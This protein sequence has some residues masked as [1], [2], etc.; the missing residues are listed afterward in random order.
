MAEDMWESDAVP[1]IVQGKQL[2]NSTSLLGLLLRL[3]KNVPIQFNSIQ[4]NSAQIGDSYVNG[5]RFR[6]EFS[7][8]RELRP[9][10][11]IFGVHTHTY[12]SSSMFGRLGPSVRRGC[13]NNSSKG[14]P[15]FPSPRK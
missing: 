1:P 14:K 12:S 10:L 5:N 3:Q 13:A 2:L 11:M 6:P 8:A 9:L 7:R 15:S 4:F